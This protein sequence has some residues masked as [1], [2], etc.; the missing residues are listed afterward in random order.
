MMSPIISATGKST[1]LPTHQTPSALPKK[2]ITK[3]PKATGLNTSFFLMERKYLEPIAKKQASTY[4][5]RL[6]SELRGV[7]IKYKMNEEIAADSTLVGTLNNFAKIKFILKHKIRRV[8]TEVKSEAG[9]NDKSPRKENKKEKRTST[10]NPYNTTRYM[11]IAFK[12]L[13]IARRSRICY[14]TLK[15]SAEKSDDMFKEKSEFRM[16]YSNAYFDNFSGGTK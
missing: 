11:V 5:W 16:Q 3:T 15:I 9:V 10:P 2:P 4:H 13:S 8:T 12:R 6:A 1:A 7:S 14:F